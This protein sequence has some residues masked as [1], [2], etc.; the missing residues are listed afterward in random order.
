M[1]QC[2]LVSKIKSYNH[3]YH[4]DPEFSYLRLSLANG[5]EWYILE[6]DAN[7]HEAYG[8]VNLNDPKN[9]EYG[10]FN[11]RELENLTWKQEV[12]DLIS[13]VPRIITHHVQID[14]IFP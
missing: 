4:I 13:G 7:T 2:L 14:N 11:I 8:Y 10:Y 1:D 5:F 3:D 9:A 12:K 6:Y